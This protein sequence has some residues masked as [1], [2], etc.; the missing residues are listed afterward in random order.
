MQNLRFRPAT[1][2]DLPILLDFEQG[3]I[4]TERPYDPT[5]KP[6]HISY[7]DIKA[8]IESADTEVVV[9]E[10][11]GQVIGSAYAQ[12]RAAKPYLQHDR[13]AYLGFMYVRPEYRG[14]GINQGIIDELKR[15]AKSLSLTEFRLD[16]YSD[17]Q[18]ALRAYQKAGFQSHL[19]TMRMGVE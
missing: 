3:I 14:R 4:E 9:A 6:G 19:I 1:F 12:L 17:N 5:L 11:D 2:A 13:Y 10:V 7:Y 16:V 15:W 18:A 8:M